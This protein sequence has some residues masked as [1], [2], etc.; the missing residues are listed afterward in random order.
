M[1]ENLSSK[2]DTGTNQEINAVME[3]IPREVNSEIIPVLD[4]FGDTMD[5]FV[6]FGS[7]F[8]LWEDYSKGGEEHI[9]PTMLIRHFLDILD[10]I[11]VLTKKCCPDTAKLLLR[12]LLETH[13]SLEYLLDSNT[14]NKSI[15]F[16]IED[17][18]AEIEVIE[19][20]ISV[21][22]TKNGKD[23]RFRVND[24][25][26]TLDGVLIKKKE[27]LQLPQFKAVFE[28]FER[29]KGKSKYYPHWYQCFNGPKTIKEIAKSLSKEDLYNN[30]YS[31]YSRNTHGTDIVGG[32]LSNEGGYAEIVQIR[33]PN[34]AQQVARF[35]VYLAN[36]TL[37][38]Y[39]VNRI[40]QKMEIYTKWFQNVQMEVN[41]IL[42]PDIIKVH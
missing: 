27:I 40:P 1:K 19:K 20:M 25:E 32:K 8:F 30:I 37:K 12:G 24:T 29:T 6:D 7:N 26:L 21:R 18:L 33:R 39:I 36:T 15:A 23:H 9:A 17:L 13:F 31:V 38:N 14:Y 42:G 22:D 3:F 10:S 11:S 34:D 35:T 2:K 16:F 4:F 28:E 41:T 5:K